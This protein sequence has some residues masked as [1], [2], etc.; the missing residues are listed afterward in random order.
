LT[1]ITPA[2]PTPCKAA[3]GQHIERGR[4]RADQCRRGVEH[5]AEAVNASIAEDVTARG[6]GQQRDHHRQLVGID[7]PD[8]I[9]GA[10]VQILGDDRQ[11][12]VDDRG[13]EARHRQP[14]H[15]GQDRP[16]ALRLRKTV[17]RWVHRSLSAVAGVGALQQT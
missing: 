10:G 15:Q 3:Q 4:E 1:L 11:G 6:E 14:D 7:D 9:G 17:F 16:I 8:R 2:A 13:I 12:D 5:E